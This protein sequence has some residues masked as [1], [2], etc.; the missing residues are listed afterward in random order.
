M[1]ES[2]ANNPVIGK[3]FHGLRSHLSSQDISTVLV[4]V[5]DQKNLPDILDRRSV[6]GMIV[7]GEFPKES[8]KEHFSDMPIVYIY[9]L[10]LIISNSS[11]IKYGEAK[12]RS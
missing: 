8:F 1:D 10:N 5:Q 6:D 3:T 11:Q 12:R 7:T 4:P 2:F 9:C